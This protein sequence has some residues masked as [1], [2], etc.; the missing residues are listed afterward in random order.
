MVL[1]AV[2]IHYLL[3]L[4]HSLGTEIVE[5]DLAANIPLPLHWYASHL[6]VL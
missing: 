6:P 1:T 3:L 5:V 2:L 4:R